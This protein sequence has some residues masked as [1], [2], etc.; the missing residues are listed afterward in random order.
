MLAAILFSSVAAF[1]AGIL[2]MAAAFFAGALLT[3]S[4]GLTGLLMFVAGI[5]G[6]IWAF[7][8]TFRRLAP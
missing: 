3:G 5:G 2:A 4:P 6:A 8:F 7:I 1:I